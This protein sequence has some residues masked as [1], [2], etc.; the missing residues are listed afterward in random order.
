MEAVRSGQQRAADGGEAAS[1]RARPSS[2]AGEDGERRPAALAGEWGEE[3]REREQSGRRWRRRR[4][5]RASVGTRQASVRPAER[6]GG[7]RPEQARE[8]A[9]SRADPRDLTSPRWCPTTKAAAATHGSAAMVLF[10]PSLSVDPNPEPPVVEAPDPKPPTSHHDADAVA[11][12]GA[13]VAGYLPF[14]N[15]RPRSALPAAGGG[16]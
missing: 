9:A 13:D 4:G 8:R 14:A 15:R 6:S 7:V 3:V 1:E 11:V 10:T 5:G 12:A 2:T 16:A